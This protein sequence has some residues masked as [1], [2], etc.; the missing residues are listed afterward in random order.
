MKYIAACEIRGD[1]FTKEFET[2][3]EAVKYAVADINRMSDSDVNKIESY[4]VIESVNPDEDAED[5]FDGNTVFD[6]KELESEADDVSTL[7]MEMIFGFSDEKQEEALRHIDLYISDMV[8]N[9]TKYRR[10]SEAEKRFLIDWAERLAKE[11]I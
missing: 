3:D 5:H 6:F 10:Y 9:D 11:N 8:E 7:V 2:A 1:I 4:L